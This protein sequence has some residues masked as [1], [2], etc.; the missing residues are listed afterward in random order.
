MGITV[1]H[2]KQKW[3][4]SGHFRQAGYH[5]VMD[6]LQPPELI[7][8]WRVKDKGK[9]LHKK[10]QK[11]QNHLKRSIP[12]FRLSGRHETLH[13]MWVW[14]KDGKGTEPKT[15][16]LP[17]SEELAG[18][19]EFLKETLHCFSSTHL[20]ATTENNILLLQKWLHWGPLKTIDISG[21]AD[22]SEYSSPQIE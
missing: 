4:Q 9:R 13:P 11:L 1:E 14:G 10:K 15:E 6:L 22:I 8:F 2:Q 3:I 17:L 12:K 19:N 5:N 18:H 20:E 21:S 7:L 16:I